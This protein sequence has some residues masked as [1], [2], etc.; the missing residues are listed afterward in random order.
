MIDTPA[1]EPLPLTAKGRGTR[2]RILDAAADLMVAKGVAAVSL[3][4]ICRVTGTSKSQLYHYFASKDELAI[5][6]VDCVRLRILAFQ[7]PL[8]VTADSFEALER[9]AA[10]MVAI[11]RGSGGGHGCPLGTLANEL[12]D[13]AE[14]ARIQL[15]AAFAEW[16]AVIAAGLASMQARGELVARADPQRLAQAVLASVQGGLL[17]AKTARDVAPL[18]VALAASLGY[19]R[20]FAA[21]DPRHDRRARATR[22]HDG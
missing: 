22:T 2:Q 4:E 15:Q 11:Q 3:D 10:T 18:E 20:T 14:R 17:M 21:A 19:L 12:A 9:W 8:L 7:R 6:V 16:E 5:A 1:R 13:T